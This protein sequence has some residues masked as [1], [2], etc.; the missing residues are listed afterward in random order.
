[1]LSAMPERNASASDF[2]SKRALLESPQTAVAGAALWF[3]HSRLP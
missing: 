2:V 1:M 3:A